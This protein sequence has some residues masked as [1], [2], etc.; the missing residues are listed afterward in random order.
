MRI[1]VA[2]D[3]PATCKLI[4]STLVAEE[5]DISTAVSLR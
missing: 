4:S 5:Y 3:D 2:D 1:L